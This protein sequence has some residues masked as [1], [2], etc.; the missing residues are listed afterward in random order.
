MLLFAVRDQSP[1]IVWG[2]SQASV[3][4]Q[5]SRCVYLG[6]RGTH[7]GEHCLFSFTGQD[8]VRSAVLIT[9][10]GLF[11]LKTETVIVGAV[12]VLQSG[13]GPYSIQIIA[14]GHECL[15]LG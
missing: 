3:S 8:T 10:D 13:E 1:L 7:E 9:N 5:Y 11:T 14:R 2:Q 4:I 12:L 15:L 6:Q